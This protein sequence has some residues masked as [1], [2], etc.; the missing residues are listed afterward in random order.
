MWVWRNCHSTGRRCDCGRLAQLFKSLICYLNISSLSHFILV[1]LQQYLYKDEWLE[2]N[3]IFRASL[4]KGD[5]F[6]LTYMKCEPKHSVLPLP[7]PA[8]TT[9]KS[10]DTTHLHNQP[11][12][13]RICLRKS[14]S[15][16]T[17]RKWDNSCTLRIGMSLA[18]VS[19]KI[20][21]L[22]NWS[23]RSW[24]NRDSCSLSS[25]G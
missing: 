19:W 15:G 20:A 23:S 22:R 12:R 18:N 16:L 8:L 24:R 13:K 17:E 10:Y 21:C 7:L 11:R 4:Y 5:D 6:A 2:Y 9:N 1:P 25:R 3:P 14:T